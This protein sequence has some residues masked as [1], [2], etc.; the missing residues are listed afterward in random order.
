M[1]RNS[2]KAFPK[3]K[4]TYF[5]DKILGN[6]LAATESET[7][8][9]HRKLA[10]H[11][12]NGETLKNMTPAVVA[13]VETMLQKWKSEGEKE[14]EVFKE[15]K[16]L[17]SEVISRTAFGSSYLEGEK[18]FEMLTK[19]TVMATRNLFS[20][21]IPIIRQLWKSADEIEA[22]ELEKMIHEIVMKI[23]RKRE[24]KL[25][26]GEADN[27][28]ND[29]LGLLINSYHD[30]DE[31]NRLSIQELVGECRTFY[32]AGSETTNSSLAWTMLLLAIHADWQD[33]G[34]A[35]VMEVFGYRNPDSEGIVKLHTITMIINETLRLYPPANSMPRKVERQVRLGK[36]VLPASLELDVRFLAL[37]HNPDL[38][39]DDVHL[40][41]PERFAEGIAKATK[42]NPVAF[43]PFGLGPR[44]CVGM[45]FAMTEIKI[46]LS[47]ILQRYTFSLSPTYVHSPMLRLTIMPQHGIQLLFRPL[48]ADA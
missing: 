10:N 35:E 39:G 45:S 15:F 36:L 46:A 19:L 41:K 12:F 48:H 17:A 11:A 38:W 31:K 13:S 30:S 32:F 9:R 34:R 22:D 24:E 28:G 42:Y 14:I 43:L 23:I 20:T 5:F 44:S 16:L 40:F 8:T 27:L 29:F 37:H 2:E 21:R 3:M 4:P 26:T 6:G 1:L 47:M 33:R 18:I 25:V 7:W